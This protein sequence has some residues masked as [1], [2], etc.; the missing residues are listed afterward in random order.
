MKKKRLLIIA[1]LLTSLGSVFAQDLER[2]VLTSIRK[3]FEKKHSVKWPITL[4]KQEKE[5]NKKNKKLSAPVKSQGQLRVEAML[6]KNRE[7][8]KKRREQAKE[9]EKSDRNSDWISK[10]SKEVKS[11]A[12]SRKSMMNRWLRARSSYVKEIPRYKKALTKL[13]VQ[14]KKIRELPT[15]KLV[16]A[17][18]V[19]GAFDRKSDNQGRRSTCAAFAAVRAIEIKLSQKGIKDKN[20]SEQY[21]YWASKPKCQQSPCLKKGSWPL[22]AL[23]RSQRSQRP[24]IPL[25]NSCL[26]SGKEVKRNETQIPL[27]SNCMRGAHQVTGFKKVESL[28]AIDQALKN[29]HPVVGGFKLDEGFF[30]NTGNIAFDP[31]AKKGKGKHAGG[32]AVLLVGKIPYP[33]SANSVQ[34]DSCYLVLNSWGEGWGQGGYACISE[35]W[36]K[37]QR[38]QIPFVAVT[39]VR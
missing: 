11:W 9:A 35:R 3:D 13:P 22:K 1:L 28:A 14:E 39:G 2:H 12:S 16:D 26:Y 23:A 19:T 34:G 21:F 10:R 5:V 17:I 24:D 37:R 30:K 31:M 25:V 36:I 6:A 38:Y 27:S 7:N 29:N 4:S 32:H 20:L 33:P 18:I 8:I 15:T